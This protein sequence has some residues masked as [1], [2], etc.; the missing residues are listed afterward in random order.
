MIEVGLVTSADYLPVQEIMRY[1]PVIEDL[2]FQEISVPEIWGHD[3]VSL[4]SLL[5]YHSKKAFIS[6]GIINMFSRAPA[7]VGMTA[8]TLDELSQGRFILGLGLS[9]PRVIENWYGKSFTKPLKRTRE[10]VEIV[11]TVT[12]GNVLNYN[13]EFYGRL[14]GFK[15]SMKPVRKRVPI[16][17]AA[18]GPKNVELTAKIA[19][20]WMPFTMP[21]PSFEKEVKRVEELLRKNRRERK[22]FTITP[23]VLA[24]VGDD[25]KT[26]YLLKKHL[27]YYFGGMGDFYNQLLRRSGFE[28]E[29][30]II[31]EKWL[32]RDKEGSIKAVSDEL[33]ALTTISGTADEARE[34]LL[35]FIKAGADRPL[36][37]LPFGSTMELGLATYKALAPINFT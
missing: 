11:N 20:G 2:G 25:E 3:S 33:L 30:S 9:G 5:C 23:F 18:L 26:Q 29:A 12:S 31:K 4:L 27:A 28:E 6:S 19:D 34:K 35:A 24:A 37:S 36:L 7:L 15:L 16:H 13:S 21:L 14:Q 17:I 22:S 32:A 8:T 1:V 10:F